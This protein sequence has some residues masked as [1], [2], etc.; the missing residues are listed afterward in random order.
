MEN[1]QSFGDSE[2]LIKPIWV[3]FVHKGTKRIPLSFSTAV[4]KMYKLVGLTRI[5]DMED[6]LFV[7]RYDAEFTGDLYLIDN[8]TIPQEWENEEVIDF[9]IRLESGRRE[10]G[11]PPIDYEVAYVIECIETLEEGDLGG[12][13]LGTPNEEVFKQAWG[14]YLSNYEDK[15]TFKAEKVIMYKRVLDSFGFSFINIGG[16]LEE[17]FYYSELP[18]DETLFSGM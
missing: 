9:V 2:K 18:D 8:F 1:S 13:I 11:F 17:C 3:L 12:Y 7:E 14:K 6:V 10:L 5:M 16:F 4:D 15:Y